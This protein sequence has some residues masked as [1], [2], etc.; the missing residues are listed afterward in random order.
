M[1]QIIAGVAVGVLVVSAAAVHV[2]GFGGSLKDWFSPHPI[3]TLA[4][5]LL[6]FIGLWWQ[7]D[8]Q[9]KNTLQANAEKDRNAL[10]LEIYRDLAATSED[11]DRSLIRTIELATVA[12]SSVELHNTWSNCSTAV[13]ALMTRLEKW[14]IAL[15]P[16]CAAVRRALG[17]GLAEVNTAAANLLS[18]ME[19]PGS[20][21]QDASVALHGATFELAGVVWDI[22]IETQNMLLGGLFTYRIPRRQP[23]DPSI[24]VATLE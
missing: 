16:R 22:R 7:L 20:I 8:V 1:K 3:L 6:G 21:L 14:E 10:K 23:P 19:T 18:A 4:G 17:E 9:H 15:G 2:L 5:V 24:R 12:P 13:V 11:A